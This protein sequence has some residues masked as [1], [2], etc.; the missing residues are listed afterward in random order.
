MTAQLALADFGDHGLLLVGGKDRVSLLQ[1]ITSNDQKKLAPGRGGYGCFT[2]AK[3]RI[4]DRSLF[5]AGDDTILVVT[6]PGR[7]APVAQWIDRYVITEDVKVADLSANVVML[8][9]VGGGAL[10]VGGRIDAR[11]A[12]LERHAHVTTKLGAVEPVTLV[13]TAGLLDAPGVLVIAPRDR[14]D[15]VL[16]ELAKAAPGIATLR[17]EQWESQRIAAGIPR[18]GVDY[19]EENNPLESGFWDA[20]SFEKGCYVGQEVV[21]RLRNYDKVMK[22]LCALGGAGAAP[23]V[24]SV[25]FAD[26]REVGKVSSVTALE[27]GEWR[28][29]GF[30]N[31]RVVQAGTEV[32]IGSLESPQRALPRALK[33]D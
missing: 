26:G 2:T 5:L 23:A 18:F 13:V 1:R 32:A 17:A 12:T 30:V 6:N 22:Q 9:L 27:S 20:V 19:G 21:A 4:V 11:V 16:A 28:A 15:E 25:L 3:G 29:L 24:G 14:R 8:E 7:A 33:F 10:E 31:R